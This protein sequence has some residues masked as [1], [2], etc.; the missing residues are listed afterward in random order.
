MRVIKNAETALVNLYI[1]KDPDDDSEDI[2]YIGITTQKLS[3]RLYKHMYDAKKYPNTHKSRWISS[4]VKLNKKPVIQ[5]L[6]TIIGWSNACS[7]EVELIKE[8]KIKG[9]NLTNSTKGGDGITGLVFS[10]EHK[11]NL[12]L[13]HLGKVL[14]EDHKRKIGIASKN[15]KLSDEFIEQMKNTIITEDTKLKMSIA[16]K[17][18]KFSDSHRKNISNAVKGKNHRMFGKHHSAEIREKIRLSCIN[19][20]NKNKLYE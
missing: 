6:E 16:Q 19:S 14:T 4:L 18:R 15:R 17:G 1:L 3:T 7:R 12:S 2:R 9:Y 20:K 13:S 5:L 8:F 10:E 11:K